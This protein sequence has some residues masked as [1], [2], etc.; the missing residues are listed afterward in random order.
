MKY[1]ILGPRKGINR[2]SD[3][4]PAPASIGPNSTVVEISDEQAATVAAG[5]SATPS[6]MY[7]LIDGQLLTLAQRVEQEQAAANAAKSWSLEDWVTHVGFGGVRLPALMDFE[8]KLKEAG[9]TSTL[10]TDTRNW[11]NAAMVR[12]ATV[13]HSA[14]AAEWGNPPHTFEAIAADALTVLSN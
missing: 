8:N 2:I 5:R 1:A 4:Q 6:V 12:Y 3:T 14:T 13:G 9:K 7:F 11:L 10:V